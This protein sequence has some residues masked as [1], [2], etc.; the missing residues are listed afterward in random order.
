[1]AKTFIF[2][3]FGGSWWLV[4]SPCCDPLLRKMIIQAAKRTAKITK[5]HSPV[6]EEV[7]HQ[8]T[9]IPSRELTYPTLGKGKSS[10]K[11]HFWWD[12][13]IPRRVNFWRWIDFNSIWSNFLFF[14]KPQSMAFLVLGGLAYFLP[15]L[16]G[17]P[18][19]GQRVKGCYN[20]PSLNP[21][22]WAKEITVK[23][24]QKSC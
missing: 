6:T 24:V 13:L 16:G 19:C 17:W 9:Q 1:M 4:A 8:Q 2:Q 18:T 10:S 7:K 20:L 11:C 21:C 5:Q 3:C 15:H 12:M 22:C 23:V 14:P